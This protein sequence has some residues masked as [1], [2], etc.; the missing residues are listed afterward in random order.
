VARD[1]IGPD[2]LIADPDLRA[3][4]GAA[5]QILARSAGR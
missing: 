1:A 2:G 5:L 3:R 4:L